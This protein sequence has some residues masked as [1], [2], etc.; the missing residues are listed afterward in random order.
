MVPASG[1]TLK[2]ATSYHLDEYNDIG[3]GYP[4]MKFERVKY[5]TVHMGGFPV[6][7]SG[8]RSCPETNN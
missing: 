1:L 5:K 7:G 3:L 2:H 4:E 6:W 8:G